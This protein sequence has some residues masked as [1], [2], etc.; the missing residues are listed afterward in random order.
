VKNA[1]NIHHDACVDHA[2]PAM[3]HDVI[4]SSHAMMLHLVLHM[5]MVDLGTLNMLFLMRLRLGMYLMVPLCYFIHVM[6][7]MYCIARM[8]KL[9]LQMWDQ[10]ARRVRLA[11]GFQNLL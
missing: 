9:L 2:M 5:F 10:N 6:L 7:L 8:I 1:H 4:Y 3:C 11:F